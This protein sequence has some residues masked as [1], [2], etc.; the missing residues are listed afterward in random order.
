MYG[1][2]TLVCAP[3][4]S[5][6]TRSYPMRRGQEKRP[7]CFHSVLWTASASAVLLLCALLCS[8]CLAG[9]A[10]E[11][12]SLVLHKSL[13]DLFN[14][15]NA[16]WT[17]SLGTPNAE[18]SSDMWT[19]M[20]EVRV[21]AQPSESAASLLFTL[22][23]SSSKHRMDD[24]EA[25][26][27]DEDGVATGKQSATR[28]GNAFTRAQYRKPFGRLARSFR[29]MS[30]EEY[31]TGGRGPQ[32]TVQGR[33]F[34]LSDS[35]EDFFISYEVN[36]TDNHKAK[37]GSEESAAT[38]IPTAMRRR[39]QGRATENV[40][41]SPHAKVRSSVEVPG[42]EPRI[43]RS[44]STSGL[45]TEH[46]LLD[47]S[48][49]ASSKE[50]NAGATEGHVRVGDVT[51]DE[52]IREMAD[53]HRS[54]QVVLKLAIVVPPKTAASSDGDTQ[55]VMHVRLECVTGT[56]YEDV[57]KRNTGAVKAARTTFFHRWVWPVLLVTAI[58]G[59]LTATARLVAWRKAAQ[60]SVASATA[61]A[62]RKQRDERLHGYA[63]HIYGC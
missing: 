53:A 41:T 38:K 34:F 2:T 36:N 31:R 14:A 50:T 8:C 24:A 18:T 45:W 47:N 52:Y 23:P 28:N 29:G 12:E 3:L 1:I 17:V 56:F 57:V 62:A 6:S 61:G 48:A 60:G 7:G 26:K 22:R 25:E 9:A 42:A 44:S 55:E 40:M 27:Y 21:E 15:E 19:T 33:C 30:C 63:G 13:V 16:L 49:A 58:Y 10:V 54:K 4:S 39:G 20:H 35:S 5:V 59:M 46:I 32:G 11:Q 43:V 37:S 51:I